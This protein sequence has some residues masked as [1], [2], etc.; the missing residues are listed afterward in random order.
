M[1]KAVASLTIFSL[2]VALSTAPAIGP[3]GAAHAASFNCAQAATPT[4]VAICGDAAL[5]QIDG[6]IGA[7][8][9]QRLASDPSLKQVQRGWL[10]TRNLGCGQDRGCLRRMMTYELSWLNSG[11]RPTGS[12]P[13]SVGVCGLSTVTRVGY[14]MGTPDSGSAIAEANGATQISY[15]DIREVDASRVADPV[16]VCLVGLPTDCPPGDD[17]GKTYAAAN[18]RTLGAWTAA[19]SQHSCGGA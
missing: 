10:K 15:D 9:V 19:D 11:G 13:K 16:L 1:R 4:E 2:V 12:L 6:S 3:V 14:R 18:L 8:Y 7:A 5:S 17:R